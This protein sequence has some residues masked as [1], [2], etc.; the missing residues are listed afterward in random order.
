MTQVTHELPEPSDSA[1]ARY[2]QWHGLSAEAPATLN[3]ALRDAISALRGLLYP[4]SDNELTDPELAVLRRGGIAVAEYPGTPDPL[5]DYAVEFA[6]ILSTSLSPADAAGRLG[7]SPARVR[8]TIQSGALFAVRV[9]GRWRV[10]LFQF[11]PDGLVPNIGAVNGAAPG[12]I[13]AVSLQRWYTTPDPDLRA[14]DE[15]TLSPLEWLK[16]GRDPTPVIAAARE[17]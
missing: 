17:L 2:F 5:A 12:T 15:R 7:V 6:A 11:T 9:G 13:D 10:P 3:Q 4:A 16:A 14:P 1:D 8:Q